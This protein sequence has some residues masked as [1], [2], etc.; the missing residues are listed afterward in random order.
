MDSTFEKNFIT[1][2]NA[3]ELSGY[4][5][6]YLARLARSGKI[7]GKRVGHSWFVEK[8]SLERF[9]DQQGIHKIDY[10][11]SLARKREVEYRVLNSPLNKVANKLT[12]PILMPRKLIGVSDSL[13]SNAFAISMSFVV[14]ASGAF[15]ARAEVIPLL[16]D[17]AI[18]IAQKIN[19]G[20]NETFGNIPSRI[21]SEINSASNELS[22][23]PA[24]VIARSEFNSGKIASS[25]LSNPDLSSLR[26]AIVSNQNVRVAT[27]LGGETTK[28]VVTSDD[29]RAFTTEAYAFV[30]NPLSIA[31]SLARAYVAIGNKTYSALIT[32]LSSYRSL[33]LYSGTKSL[34][35]AAH[36]RDILAATP[37]IVSKI[38]LAFG[39]AIIKATHSAI[40]ADI[41]TAYGLADAAPASA[42]ATVAL[43][44]NAGNTLAGV[45]ARAPII[46]KALFLRTTAMPSTLAP[47]LARAIF[48]AEYASVS[49]L[50]AFAG[51]A[52]EHYLSGL[53]TAGHLS[54]SAVVGSIALTHSTESFIAAIPT[55][56]EDTYLGTLGKSALALRNFSEEGLTSISRIPKIASVLAAVAPT[57]SVGEQVALATYK[58][59]SGFFNSANHAL[60]TLFGQPPTI[61]LPSG[62]PNA[63]VTTVAT[64][65]TKISNISQ[66]S[67]SY[68]SYTTVV[69]GVS[70]DFMNQS[71]ASLR[72]DVLATVAG[73]IQPVSRQTATNAVTI[74]EV[75]RIEDLSN[76]I[77]RNGDFRG[78]TFSGGGSMTGGISVS[79]VTGSFTN[80][81]ATGTVAF[82]TTEITGDLTVSGT[83][84]PAL[85]SASTSISAPYFVAT[86]TTATSTFAGRLAVGTTTPFGDGIFTIGTTT[87]LLYISSNTGRIGVGTSS[88]AVAFDIYATDAFRIPVGTTA[89]RPAIGDIGFIRYNITKHQFEGYGDDS[90][91]QGL[92]GVVD[93]DQSTYITADTSNTNEDILRFVTADV[94][95]MAITSTGL[96]GIGTTSPYSLLSIS[97]SVNTAVNTPLFTIASTT[98]GTAT[99][100]LMTILAN[101]RIGI[102]TSTP[103]AL[104]SL[105]QPSDGTPM[106]SMYRANG[107]TLGDFIS[108]KSNDGTTLFRVDNSGNLLAGGIVNSGSETITSTSQPQFRIQYDSNNEFIV[109][110]GLTGT[111]TITMNGSAPGLVFAPQ[112]GKDSINMFNFTNSTNSSVLSIDTLNTRIGIAT[113]SPFAALSIA[114]SAGG[115]TNL[116]AISTSTSGFATT[117]ALTVNQNGNLSL[118]GG[119]HLSVGNT[120]ATNIAGDGATSTVYG[121]LSVRGTSSQASSLTLQRGLNNTN[122]T[123]AFNDQVGASLLR[124]YTDANT[125]NAYIVGDQSNLKL[126]TLVGGTALSIDTLH[127]VNATANIIPTS[128]EDYDLG[129]PALYWDNG[130]LRNIV[131]NNLSSASSSIAGTNTTTFSINSSNP[132]S[133][134][135][136]MSLIFY[137]GAGAASNGVLS[138]NSTLK[139]FEFNQNLYVSNA[140]ASTASTTLALAAVSGQTGALTNWLDSSGNVLSTVTAGGSLGIGTTSPYSLLSINNSVST[141]ANT[142]LFTI[143][144]T[145]NGT[146]TSTLM[147][148]LN[149]G[150]VGFGTG[151]TLDSKAVVEIRNISG[152]DDGEAVLVLR[153]SL[154]SADNASELRLGKSRGTY[155][156][157]TAILSGDY[158]GEVDFIGF[159]GGELSTSWHNNAR[160]EGGAG[161]NWTTTS[162]ETFIDFTTT[163]NGSI[164]TNERMRITGSGNIGIGT[165]TPNTQLT[166][167]TSSANGINLDADTG[168]RTR[169][170]RLFF[171]TGTTGQAAVIRNVS[172]NL[173]FGNTALVGLDSGTE[174]MRIDTSG[175]VGIGTTSPTYKL[176]VEGIGSFGDYARA[177]YFTATSTIATSTFAGGL[178]V[179]T[180]GLVY[181]YSSGNVGIGTAEPIYKL[182]VVG[183]IYSNTGEY[184]LD[185][186]KGI[187]WGDGN[188][189]IYGTNSAGLSFR[190]G[191][192]ANERLV[193]LDGG[194]VG[195]GTTSPTNLL[196]VS[197]SSAA[198]YININATAATQAG[199]SFSKDQTQKWVQYVPAS[200]NDLRFYDGQDRV[201]FQNGGNVGIGTTSP[202][203]KLDIAGGLANVHTMIGTGNSDSIP[204][205][206]TGNGGVGDWAGTTD[207][208][209]WMYR[210]TDGNLELDRRS[211]SAS[212]NQVLTI[213]RST[214]NLGLG[215]TSPYSLLS[216]QATAGGTTPLFTIASSTAGLATSTALM[217]LANGNV[218]IGTAAPS[219][220]MDISKMDDIPML[221]LSHNTAAYPSTFDKLQIST[222]DTYSL[223]AHVENTAD[224]GSG[225]GI[226]NFQTN[227][228]EGTNPTYGGFAFKGPS[229]TFVRILNNGNVGIGQTSPTT[230]LQI[231]GGSSGVMNYKPTGGQT[232]LAL[233]TSTAPAIN[234]GTML[235]LGGRYTTGN[236]YN[237]TFAAIGGLKENAT[238]NDASGYMSFYVGKDA[239]ANAAE[240]MRITSGGNV[241]IGTVSPAGTLDVNG[242]IL[243]PG[244]TGNTMVRPAIGA[245]RITGEIS[246]Y[247]TGT[248]AA[249]DGFL[250]LSAGGGTNTA[251]RSYI[252]LSGYSTVA[253]MN[254]NIT[255]GVAGVEKVRINSDGN[256]GIGT[257]SPGVAMGGWAYGTGMKV[258]QV[259][260]TGNQDAILHLAG[261][262]T[263]RPM[264]LMENTSSTAGSRLFMI[265]HVTDAVRFETLSEVDG[266]N[267]REIMRFNTITGNVGIGTTSPNWLLQVAGTRPSFA[268]SDTSASANLKHWLFSSMGG[269]LY[270]GT[271]TDAYATS[272]PSALTITN[273]GNVGIGTSSPTTYKFSVAGS[274]SLGSGDEVMRISSTG[275]VGIGTTTPYAKLSLVDNTASLRDVFTISSSTTSGAVFRVDSYGRV[276][277]DGAS[278]NAGA[279]YAEYFY[280][281]SVDLKSGEVVCVDVVE[282]NAVKRC[283]RGADNN[284]MGIVSSKPSFVGNHIN[285][286]KDN[287]SHYA[288]IG[289]MGQVEA[290]VSAENGAISVGDSLTSASS[291]PGMAMRADNG[292]STVAVA[293]EPLKEG[294]GTI[295]VLISRRNKSMAVEEVESLVVERI[296]NMKIE[297]RVQQLVKDAT[298]NIVL[299]KL[300]ISGTVS[301]GAY[302]VALMPVTGFA[303]GSTTPT[304]GTTTVMAE[305]PSAVLTAD[306]EGVDIYKLATYTLSGVQ[307]LAMKVEAHEVR[308]ASLETRVAALENGTISSSGDSS[309][310]TTSLASVLEG[311]GVFIQRGFAQFGTLVADQFVA[312]TNS[313]G[314]SS[315]GTITILAG[316]TV[317]QVTNAFV[318]PTSK[319]F[320]TLT[321]STTGSWYIS[322]KQNGSFKL[323]LESAQATDVSFD[324][325]LIQTEGQMATSSPEVIINSEPVIET[326][327]ITTDTPPSTSTSPV[328]DTSTSSSSDTTPPVVTLIGEA[329]IEITVNDTI[330]DPGATATDDID[331]DL[332]TSIVVAGSVDTTTAGLYT[333]T[334]TATDA[335]GNV[336]SVS[337]V[338]TVL[339]SV[340]SST[341][342]AEPVIETPVEPITEPVTETPVEPTAEPVVEQVVEPVVDTVPVA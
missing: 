281:N 181:D 278:Y 111:T 253:D 17:Q 195:I 302:D 334:Y 232:L 247:R 340:E 269:N 252:D 215:T 2:K 118:L 276:Y 333:L 138:W 133:D 139:R 112:S 100:T 282:N 55:V 196:V 62:T 14:V 15:I 226:L 36:N 242:A 267:E 43:V 24:R 86:S 124:I 225:Y 20:F 143:A 208:F 113:T 307:A 31:D 169:S 11:R 331:G 98:A 115:G 59:I 173:V 126:G 233:S 4:S 338:V 153:T 235:V 165:T 116:F 121:P 82:G 89:Q 273:A 216:V 23:Y 67:N 221:Q 172:G 243:L 129:S 185:S 78:G 135:Q 304:L 9:L 53:V 30:A 54:Y 288:I 284:V 298:D 136:D 101:G 316:N 227:A 223:I 326:P 130:Y 79:A 319:I 73:M 149:N 84:T 261:T 131:A 179:E 141:P 167:T 97:N 106:I 3:G 268:L 325:F 114:G 237:A 296:A 222:T 291:T 297:D 295:K 75:N 177:S 92:G 50:V 285:S 213:Q 108:Y 202:Q 70:E 248:L 148:V 187:I 228:A 16:A 256:V 201:T 266:S 272:S 322:D 110:T 8:E 41:I 193:I 192:A 83:I 289:M 18:I 168:D 255:F 19:Y 120:S 94:Q 230:L 25:I 270:I 274:A 68:P 99:S 140:T 109:S 80:L 158:L 22:A 66:I 335:A 317:A 58:T 12:K 329:A 314:T 45:T 190:T 328:I 74:R 125:G 117:T 293:L 312:A 166:I 44:G 204:F 315:A 151:N 48:D 40:H 1:T 147:T 164:T 72:S 146:A 127:N 217:V 104:L 241:G 188:Q 301:A 160:M 191:G 246:G 199:I 144:S 283:E 240:K 287:P 219:A 42:R 154:D 186:G 239:V 311:L 194:N 205:L 87:P 13:R 132:T 163:P 180:S 95:R 183:N 260:A 220:Q 81:S 157:P 61:V 313:A 212:N 323:V 309:F 277:G 218:G 6:D 258:L 308:L 337:R 303:F 339:A 69:K 145:T 51:S 290:F 34:V 29:M 123:I 47:A 174:R 300:A 119:A 211:G 318:K 332:T 286:V 257:T 76:L 103:D 229:T 128:N 21:A 245:A 142:P 249:D 251:T 262:G 170:A 32:S 77:V 150:R 189:R 310:S 155:A 231:G 306:G 234:L 250:R 52:S 236:D 159:D 271:S 10:A 320:V 102:G 330:T 280:T 254:E 264:L 244:S 327:P 161:S 209:A 198:N 294:T 203:V 152:W 200:S 88:P 91:W 182:Q 341:S 46:A 56:L 178:A 49:P 93:A 175:L 26:M 197:G 27:Q 292:D 85:I 39:G 321:A 65:T 176:S 90:A 7:I 206:A 275:N 210:A 184:Y 207:G 96:I 265:D 122:N 107:I 57:L 35:F 305:I 38:N 238:D 71:L 324:Y 259:E 263:R 214:G 137:R 105:L 279:D 162:H 63:R 156:N 336:G 342:P 37:S 5:S 299:E 60:A 224:A 64:T 33:I 171:S 134:T 28:S